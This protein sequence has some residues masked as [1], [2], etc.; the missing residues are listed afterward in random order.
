MLATACY[1]AARRY[2]YRVD[3]EWPPL[4]PLYAMDTNASIRDGYFPTLYAKVASAHALL[5]G[6]GMP[7]GTPLPAW[8]VFADA[9]VAFLNPRFNLTDAIHT[10]QMARDK[11]QPNS[12]PSARRCHVILQKSAHTPNT[13]FIFAANTPET[14]SILSAWWLDMR[15]HGWGAER[16]HEQTMFT[17]SILRLFGEAWLDTNGGALPPTNIDLRELAI[18][19]RDGNLCWDKSLYSAFIDCSMQSAA[20]LMGV[21]SL[22]GLSMYAGGLCIADEERMP[23]FNLYEEVTPGATAH[24]HSPQIMAAATLAWKNMNSFGDCPVGCSPDTKDFSVDIEL[25]K[26][27]VRWRN[28]NPSIVASAADIARGLH[29]IYDQ[30]CHTHIRS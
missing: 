1:A 2:T 3:V 23:V 27:G 18:A 20:M 25:D 14:R 17:A 4:H 19:A 5:D 30:S 12:S 22:R 29:S 26:L 8:V 10:V 21:R 15:K 9:D 24:G 6:L 7:E 13:G 16:G 28:D 11:A